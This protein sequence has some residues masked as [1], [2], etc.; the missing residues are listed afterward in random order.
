MPPFARSA[1]ITNGS[2]QAFI[3]LGQ[4]NSGC[5]MMRKAFIAAGC[6]GD[7]VKGIQV[8]DLRRG[9]LPDKIV[10]ARSGPNE[11]GTD[12]LELAQICMDAGYHVTPILI[13]RKT[14]FAL[15]GHCQHYGLTLEEARE[16]RETMTYLAYELAAWLGVTLVVVPYE[17]FVTSAS[18]RRLLFWQLGLQ[19]PAMDFFNAN[20]K[21]ELDGP[22]LPY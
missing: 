19:E 7:T 10:L 6:Y 12:F 13:Y 15:A 21:Y 2:K 8:K 9:G 18:V 5:R 11:G 1:L 4:A 22:P 3:I 20:E 17:P 14:D 16:Y